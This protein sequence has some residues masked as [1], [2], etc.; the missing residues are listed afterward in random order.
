[1]DANRTSSGYEL[2]DEL[3]R[4]CLCA[5]RREPERK[6]AWVNSVCILFLLIGIL[7][8]RQGVIAIKP[9]PPIRQ[10]VPVVVQPTVLPPQPVAS[11]P[12]QEQQNNQPLVRVALPNA[13]NVNFG[14]PTAG[15]LA[16]K[17]ALASAPQPAP[18]RIGSLSNTGTGGERPEPPYPPIAEQTGEQGMMVLVLTGDDA[19]NV[20]SVDVKESSGFPLLDR[21]TVDFIKRHWRLP[22]DTGTRLFQTSITYKLQMN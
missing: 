15:T 11:K 9:V 8:A 10:V 18:V 12:E 13:P 5:A 22:T 2:K 7:G 3:A 4:L 20:V 1:M 19:G 6:L 21:A 14:V 17:A 16:T